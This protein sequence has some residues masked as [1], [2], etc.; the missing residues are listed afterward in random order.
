[1]RHSFYRQTWNDNLPYDNF[2]YSKGNNEIAVFGHPESGSSLTTA[3]LKGKTIDSGNEEGTNNSYSNNY[4]Q[5]PGYTV[6][7]RY[8]YIPTMY[9]N[10]T[11]T[12]RMET[13]GIFRNAFDAMAYT[14]DGRAAAD[15]SSAI[16]TGYRYDEDNGA[17]KITYTG[18]DTHINKL[19]HGCIVVFENGAIIFPV[20]TKVFENN[21]NAPGEMVAY[22]EDIYPGISLTGETIDYEKLLSM[23]TI[24][25]TMRVPSVYKP[26]YANVEA[27]IWNVH[28]LSIGTDDKGKTIINTE[29]LPLSYDVVGK[30]HNG[31]TFEGKFYS[32]D[33]N[34]EYSTYLNFKNSNEL[35]NKLTTETENDYEFGNLK[36][37]NIPRQISEATQ[38]AEDLTNIEYSITEG[39]PVV[40]D[41]SNILT[42]RYEGGFDKTVI[43]DAVDTTSSFYTNLKIKILT[44]RGLYGDC[45]LYTDGNIPETNLTVYVISASAT[46]F[47]K[48]DD[49]L[50]VKDGNKTFCYGIYNEKAKFDTKGNETIVLREGRDLIASFTNESGQII[51]K[52]IIGESN[53]EVCGITLLHGYQIQNPEDAVTMVKNV[54]TAS[55]SKEIKVYTMGDTEYDEDDKFAP[56]EGNEYGN[57]ICVYKKDETSGTKNT[58]LLYK[59]YSLGSLKPIYP[60]SIDGNEPYI[61]AVD[62]VEY[63][64]DEHVDLSLQVSSNV[65]F[66]ASTEDSWITLLEP[67]V[68]YPAGNSVIQFSISSNSGPARNGSIKLI[69]IESDAST[70]RTVEIKQSAAE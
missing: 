20:V 4:S 15:A 62:S 51:Q 21:N 29:S 59:L 45:V 12:T 44:D 65:S 31:L 19:G 70:E 1:M 64:S 8:T 22:G 57:I 53:L 56:K 25:R 5:F 66:T 14:D 49:P 33:T 50:I 24:Y 41:D 43:K 42:E 28:S 38:N 46:I 40:N 61:D 11:G 67:E 63:N 60:V 69:S 52:T 9:F 10:W 34:S 48:S 23:A 13:N 26:F 47:K 27:A 54:I 55:T 18:G 3:E 58:M 7:E 6:D 35:Y 39:F 36:S 30:V 17:I 2:I 37:F 16:I 68:Q 32:G